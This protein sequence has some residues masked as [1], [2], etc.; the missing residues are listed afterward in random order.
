MSE[1][2]ADTISPS[3][4]ALRVIVPEILGIFFAEGPSPTRSSPKKMY[5]VLRAASSAQAAEQGEVLRGERGRVLE[6][7]RDD[8][9]ASLPRFLHGGDRHV[10]RH[11]LSDAREVPR[12]DVGGAERPGPAAARVVGRGG[13]SLSRRSNVEPVG[14]PFFERLFEDR[15]GGA[16]RVV[17]PRGEDFRREEGD[18]LARRKGGRGKAQKGRKEEERGRPRTGRHRSREEIFLNSG[19]AATFSIWKTAVSVLTTTAPASRRAAMPLW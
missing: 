16:Q 1:N 7:A 12:E 15:D 4:V 10:E 18:G 3:I 13:G 19:V 6:R 17:G 11:R 2:A 8:D 5:F 9:G 14:E